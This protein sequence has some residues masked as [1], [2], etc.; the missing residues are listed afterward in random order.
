MEDIEKKIVF[1]EKYLDA[2]IEAEQVRDY[3]AWVKHYEN[4]NPENF[5]EKAFQK[6]M[7]EDRKELG[8]Y[9]TRKYLGVLN[10][11]NENPQVDTYPNC[12]RFIWRGIFEKNETLIVL[13]IHERDGSYFVNE[14]LYF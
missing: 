11:F 14:N 13:G 5:D 10:G 7:D 2:M 9:I 6:S 1:A 3:S 12:L 4:Q 8:K